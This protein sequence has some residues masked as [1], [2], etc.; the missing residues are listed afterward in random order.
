VGEAAFKIVATD[1]APVG[2]EISLTVVGTANVNGRNYQF[3]A[4]GIKLTVNAPEGS[5]EAAT[6]AE[7]PK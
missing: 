3:R 6:S 5:A 2:K 7:A 4:P 1:K